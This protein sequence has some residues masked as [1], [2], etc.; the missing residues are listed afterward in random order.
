MPRRHPSTPRGAALEIVSPR[1]SARRGVGFMPAK[2]PVRVHV[3]SGIVPTE[4]EVR[5]A[6]G[7]HAFG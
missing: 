4:H 6:E 5:T 1:P 3:R 2:W 7:K